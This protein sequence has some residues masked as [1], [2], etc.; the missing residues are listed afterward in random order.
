MSGRTRPRISAF[1][2]PCQTSWLFRKPHKMALPL[3]DFR[4]LR[5]T[6]KC[7]C[8]FWKPSWKPW[9]QGVQE[10]FQSSPQSLFRTYPT[11][12]RP[13]NPSWTVKRWPDWSPWRG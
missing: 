9:D 2:T 3:C 5:K 8:T 6:E 13:T 10:G 4:T 7:N 11:H 12:Y 1:D